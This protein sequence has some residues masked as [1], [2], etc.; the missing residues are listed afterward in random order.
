MT[1]L[2]EWRAWHLAS[3]HELEDRPYKPPPGYPPVLVVWCS[4]G[5][6]YWDSPIGRLC[7]TLPD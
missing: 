4:C 1:T 7:T 5:G 6:Y 2:D 3:G